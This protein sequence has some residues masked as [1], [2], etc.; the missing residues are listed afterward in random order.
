MTPEAEKI[1]AVK[2]DIHGNIIWSLHD[3]GDASEAPVFQ[4]RCNNQN[5]SQ[6]FNENEN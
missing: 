2:G 6:N 1:N 4:Q 5:S 3:I